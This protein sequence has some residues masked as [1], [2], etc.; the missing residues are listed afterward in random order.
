MGG[1]E[2]ARS[3]FCQETNIKYYKRKKEKER[4]ETK[5]SRR[6]AVAVRRGGSHSNAV[7]ALVI[8]IY[9]E[10]RPSDEHHYNNIFIIYT[11]EFIMG[12]N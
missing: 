2:E 6:R 4:R 5:S 9:N 1:E 12:F 8:E 10:P 3:L 11:R 7:H